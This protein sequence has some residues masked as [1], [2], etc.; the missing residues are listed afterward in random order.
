MTDWGEGKVL[1]VAGSFA[2]ATNYA[3]ENKLNPLNWVYAGYPE[4]LRG[5]TPSRIV[6]VGTYAMRS[7][8]LDIHEELMIMAAR[9]NAV[10]KLR[11]IVVKSPS[12]KRGAK[13]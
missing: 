6:Y 8:F 13:R 10:R 3:I 12:R 7:D 9:I 5:W 2:Q 1:I 11:P 4:T